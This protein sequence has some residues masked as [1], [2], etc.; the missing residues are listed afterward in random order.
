M[1]RTAV[2]DV[3]AV[4]ASAGDGAVQ[5]LAPPTRRTKIA[6]CQTLIVTSGCGSASRLVPAGEKALAWGDAHEGDDAYRHSGALNVKNVD[7][8]DKVSDEQ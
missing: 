2:I 6:A 4:F 7:W 5:H 8:L 3:V 1:P